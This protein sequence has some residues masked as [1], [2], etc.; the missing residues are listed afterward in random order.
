MTYGISTTVDRP[1][2]AT[3]AAVREALGTQGFGVLTEFDLAATLKAKLD[4][5]VAPQ[6]VLGACNPPLAHRALQA[7]ASIGL[8]L[9]CNVV[10]RALDDGRTIVEALDPDVMVGVTGNDGLADV[11]QDAGTR[12]RAALDQLTAH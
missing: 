4:V 7:E 6:V 3:L 11:A 8:L 1:F 9:P 12:L 5:D 10:V 2:D